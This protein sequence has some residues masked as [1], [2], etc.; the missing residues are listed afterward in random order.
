MRIFQF[1]SL[2]L[3]G[4]LLS[5][6][7]TV[8][9]GTTESLNIISN[10]VG[11]TVEA[12]LLLQSGKLD[13]ANKNRSKILSCAPTPCSVEIPRINH[14][15]VTVSKDGYQSIKFLAA[16]K[17]SSPTS[18]I[19]PGMVVAGTSPGS[20]VIAGKPET[21]TKYISGNTMTAMQILSFY[22]TAGTV[23]D[24]VSGAN[25]SLSPNPVTVV[26]APVNIQP[27]EEDKPK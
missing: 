19:K 10:P 25:R 21:I 1:A 12:E 15:R 16:S 14:A 18:T 13:T 4:F 26:L 9:R 6:C 20:H 11:A 27:S 8:S 22:G 17:G 2:A 3:F 7:L 23:V 24:K 5:G